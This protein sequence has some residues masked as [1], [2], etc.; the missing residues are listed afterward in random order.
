MITQKINHPAFGKVT[1][2]YK[3]GQ[4]GNGRLALMLTH[5][6][7]N[8]PFCVLTVN[9]P[10]DNLEEHEFFVK[11]WSE[12]EFIANLLRNGT[13][14]IDTGKRVPTGHVVAE[15]WKFREPHMTDLITDVNARR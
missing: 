2:E 1:L 15:V 12:N 4:Y 8:L 3:R 13:H 10:D 9:L 7:D 6:E 11:G 5:A 14:F